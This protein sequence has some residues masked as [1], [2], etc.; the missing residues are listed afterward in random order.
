[1]RVAFAK[2]FRLGTRIMNVHNTDNSA[3][4]FPFRREGLENKQASP[5]ILCTLEAFL[6]M[7]VRM[8]NSGLT[9]L[10]ADPGVGHVLRSFV[11]EIWCTGVKTQS[12]AWIP[13][14][15]L[16]L[17]PLRFLTR[18]MD[19]T[20]RAVHSASSQITAIC[21]VV[22]DRKHLVVHFEQTFVFTLHLNLSPQ[23]FVLLFNSNFETR[24]TPHIICVAC[25]HAEDNSSGPQ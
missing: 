12:A 3:A 1:M 15:I 18:I 17:F 8:T 21:Q 19:R 6:L 20:A 24:P 14:P 11:P 2:L 13:P 4:C 7:F 16:R 25:A 5:L 23:I 22:H 10:P 9:A